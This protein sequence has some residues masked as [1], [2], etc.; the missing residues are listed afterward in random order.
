VIPFGVEMV[1]GSH[2]DAPRLWL[3]LSSLRSAS[4]LPPDVA[5]AYEMHIGVQPASPRLWLPLR[6][7]LQQTDGAI[8]L[9]APFSFEMVRGLDVRAPVWQPRREVLYLLVVVTAGGAAPRLMTAEAWSCAVMEA[10]G[11]SASVT[12]ESAWPCVV[13]VTDA[14]EGDR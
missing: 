10:H 3:P 14:R 5:Q 8:H 9:A 7:G 11:W 13:V 6:I 2:P 4:I 1:Q 12:A